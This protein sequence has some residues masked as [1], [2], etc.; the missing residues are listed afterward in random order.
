MPAPTLSNTYAFTTSATSLINAAFRAINVI[1]EEETATGY[2]LQEGMDALNLMVKAWGATQMHVWS[3]TTQTIT[4]VAG[5]AVYQ[6]GIGSPHVD[7]VRPLRVS[8]ARRVTTATGSVAPLIQ[9]ARVDYANLSN[10]VTP[11]GTP[12][13]YFYDPQIP[14]GELTLYPAPSVDDVAASTYEITSL[15]PIMDFDTLANAPD[16]PTEWF[17]ALKWNLALELAPPYGVPLDELAPI[18]ALAERYFKIVKDWDIEAQGTTSLPFSQPVYQIIARAM[19]LANATGPQELPTLGMTNNAFVS[20]NA[21]VKAWQGDGIHVWAIE[22]AILFPEVG[23]AMYRV[24][25]A[26]TDHFALWNTMVLSRA[27]QNG[28][29]GATT[30][31]LSTTAG[32]AAGYVF[33]LPISASEMFWTTLASDPVG[34]VVTLADPLTADVA[35][36]AAVFA[37]PSGMVRPLRVY[38]A[39]RYIYQSELENPLI[40][41]SRLDYMALPNKANRGTITEFFFDAQNDPK[42]NPQALMY[43]W[44]VPADTAFGV[45]FT[46]QRPLDGFIDLTT[47]Q[48][49]PAEWTNALVFNLAVEIAPEYNMEPTAFERLQILAAQKLQAAR[50]WDRDVGAVLFGYASQAAYRSQW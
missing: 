9:M 4:P 5:Q 39:R 25:G 27:A 34:N 30:L 48:D 1:G 12:A 38:G 36:G 15:R 49:F 3:Q 6:I 40:G 2:Q 28:A 17:A 44:P 32:M 23:Q 29:A 10:K 21:M 8:G 7:I 35:T 14:F 24:G 11:T 16:F 26:T 22:E 41:L 47:V 33:G 46:S 43:V 37:Y 45:R 19:R 20:F 13:N 42:T 50:A 31:T 18:T